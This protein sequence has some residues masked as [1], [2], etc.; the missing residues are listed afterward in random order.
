MADYHKRILLSTNADHLQLLLQPQL[1]IAA[2]VIMRSRIRMF[3][4][5]QLY[6]LKSAFYEKTH[7]RAT[8][9]RH[10]LYGI[11]PC[12]LPSDTG[13]R[14]GTRFAYPGRMKS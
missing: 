4:A 13:E 7:H 3:T 8:T 6:R 10:C 9:G 11:T 12:Y 5:F 1:G 14:A 2:A